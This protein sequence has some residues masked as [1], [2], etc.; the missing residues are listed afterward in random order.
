M[1][2]SGVLS[3]FIWVMMIQWRFLSRKH[4]KKER[5]KGENKKDKVTGRIKLVELTM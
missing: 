4:Y 5:D 3:G 1:N 2:L